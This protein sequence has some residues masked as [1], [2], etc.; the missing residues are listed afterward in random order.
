LVACIEVNESVS[1]IQPLC[2]DGSLQLQQAH[3]RISS[4]GKNAFQAGR[5]QVHFSSMSRKIEFCLGLV[6]AI[7]IRD[8]SG[9]ILR[10]M[11]IRPPFS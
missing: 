9:K 1:L 3:L 5:R 8:S 7:G 2:S 6:S 10:P 4:L 11:R